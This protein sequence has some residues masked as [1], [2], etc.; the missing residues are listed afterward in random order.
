MY[1]GRGNDSTFLQA[2]LA[3]WLSSQL[4]VNGER[5]FLNF[6]EIE[7]PRTDV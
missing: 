7:F 2:L 1:F 3:Q 5:E 4:H 6:G